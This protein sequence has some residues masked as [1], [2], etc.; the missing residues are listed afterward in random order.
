MPTSIAQKLWL[1]FML[2]SCLAAINLVQGWTANR[3][4]DTTGD[5]RQS[6]KLLFETTDSTLRSLEYKHRKPSTP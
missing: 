2:I 3:P 4:P 6:L 5:Y 1:P